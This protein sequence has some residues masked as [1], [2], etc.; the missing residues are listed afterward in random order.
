ML[1]IYGK[2]SKKFGLNLKPSQKLCVF[3]LPCDFEAQYRV[4]LIFVFPTY[5]TR[6]VRADI[7]LRQ[8]Y[9]HVSIGRNIG[10]QNVKSYS[11]VDSDRCHKT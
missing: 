8:L 10:Q 7:R 3:R 6:D 1:C 11:R 2:A 9:H 5:Q 4:P